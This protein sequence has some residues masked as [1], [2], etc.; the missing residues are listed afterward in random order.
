[1]VW[2]T[3]KKTAKKTAQI[4]GTAVE[5]GAKA[6]Y[7]GTTGF[8]NVVSDVLTIKKLLNVEKKTFTGVST[9][10]PNPLGQLYGPT[11]SGHFTIDTTPFPASGSGHSQRTGS[12]IKL[13]GSYFRFQLSQQSATASPIKFKIYVCENKG[14]TISVATNVDQTVPAVNIFEVNRWIKTTDAVNIYDYSSNLNPDRMGNWKILRTYKGVMPSDQ[15]SGILG[16][17]EVSFGVKYKNH[18]VKFIDDTTTIIR[19]QICLILVADCGNSGSI[20]ASTLTQVPI[21]VI[22]T[23]LTFRYECKHFYVDN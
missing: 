16:I 23:G 8:A 13:T 12:S 4:V 2:K 1:M 11:G 3:I 10:L 18:H 19:G 14:D 7:G 20:N 22:N 15:Y 9:S 6:R 21:T 5:R 17:K